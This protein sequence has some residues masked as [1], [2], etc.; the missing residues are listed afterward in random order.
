MKFITVIMA[1]AFSFNVF[2]GSEEHEQAQTCY[3]VVVEESSPLNANVPTQICLENLTVDTS[4]ETISAYSFFYSDLYVNLKLKSVTRKNE[5]F[6]SFKSSSVVRDEVDGSDTQKIILF[7]SG[8]VDNYG[9][10][11]LKYLTIS[12]DQVVGKTYVE[13]PYVKNTYKYK[14]Y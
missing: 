10:V 13:Y 4:N 6:F 8:Q 11:D 1:L 5:D 12:L 9:A 3:Y 14:T 2:A 7:I